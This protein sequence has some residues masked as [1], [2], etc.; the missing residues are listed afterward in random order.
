MIQPAPVSLAAFGPVS[1]YIAVSAR[2]NM[3]IQPWTAHMCR[4][5]HMVIYFDA[6]ECV[7]WCFHST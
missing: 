1:D 4:N 3:S 2:V 6:V 5:G 7:Y